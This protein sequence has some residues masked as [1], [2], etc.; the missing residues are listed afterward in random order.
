MPLIN[1]QM[2]IGRTAAQKADFIREVAT[3]A[4]RTLQVPEHAVTIIINEVDHAHWG[5]GRSTM[6]AIQSA[7]NSA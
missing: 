4:Q 7:K 5:V 6:K 2:L 1:V 3:I